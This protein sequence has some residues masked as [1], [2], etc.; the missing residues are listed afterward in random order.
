VLAV[1]VQPNADA[2]LKGLATNGKGLIY[3]PQTRQHSW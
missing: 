3:Y 2:L 1:G